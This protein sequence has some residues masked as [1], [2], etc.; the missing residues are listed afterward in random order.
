M[1]G[2]D[3]FGGRLCVML[4]GFYGSRLFAVGADVRGDS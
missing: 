2:W 1:E 3:V 4:C